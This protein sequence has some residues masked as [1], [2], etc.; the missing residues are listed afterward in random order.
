M[1]EK[2]TLFRALCV[3]PL[4]HSTCIGLHQPRLR[5]NF[6]CMNPVTEE[7]R[8]RAH[9]LLAGQND[10]ARTLG[11][12]ANRVELLNARQ[13]LL[14]P[15]HRKQTI[16]LVRLTK[17]WQAKLSRA[18]MTPVRRVVQETPAR[19][20]SNSQNVSAAEASKEVQTVPLVQAHQ[21]LQSPAQDLMPPPP[22]V[23]TPQQHLESRSTVQLQATLIH[24][25]RALES[26]IDALTRHLND[27]QDELTRTNAFRHSTATD[28]PSTVCTICLE[29]LNRDPLRLVICRLGCRR[30]FH[31]SCMDRWVSMKG[32]DELLKCPEC[33]RLWV[34]GRP[35]EMTGRRDALQ[36][37]RESGA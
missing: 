14:C 1:A 37:D 27:K 23:T 20:A 28:K 34:G 17:K 19:R 10:R 33:K 6:P 25:I 29:P 36:E 24:E 7:D 35:F 3:D 15:E 12:N 11:I 30:A 4:N 22:P 9:T 21:P 8:R 31:E 32:A 26:Q 16:Q 2:Q 5:N 13:L 18:N